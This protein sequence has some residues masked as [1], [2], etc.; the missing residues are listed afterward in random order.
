MNTYICK[1]GKTFQKSS[2]ADSTGYVLKNFDLQHECYGCPY[3]VTERDWITQEIKKQECRATPKITYV[4][5]CCIGT[6]DKNFKACHLYTLDLDFAKKVLDFIKSLD[7]AAKGD[8]SFTPN[9]FPNEW[10]AADFGLCYDFDDCCGLAIFPLCFQ[11]NK[12][13]TEARRTVMNRFFYSD[14]TRKDI[15]SDDEKQYILWQIENAKKQ[16]KSRITNITEE[17]RMSSKFDLSTML[18]PSTVNTEYAKAA[19]IHA[20]IINYA[21][22]AQENLYQMAL[23][24]KKMRDEKLYTAL[25]YDNFAEYCEKETGMKRGN[26]YKYIAVA[27]KLPQEFVSPVRQIGVQKLYL[28]TTITEDEREDIADTIDL[29]ST[30]VK[31]LKTKIDE[32][33]NKNAELEKSHNELEETQNIYENRIS[34]LEKAIDELENKPIEVA[35]Q[36]NDDEINRL[37]SELE[38]L[39]QEKEEKNNIEQ[40]RDEKLI[41][42]KAA[43]RNA[44]N[45][46]HTLQTEC[47][48]YA[49]FGGYLDAISLC[50]EIT[51]TLKKIKSETFDL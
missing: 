1:C 25:G 38:T 23:G 17:C 31:E 18:K 28:L 50:E 10:R 33:K 44:K 22:M 16:A 5:R 39:K 6:E 51:K 29:E 41:A 48:K 46:L 35:I 7:G 13:G 43:Y 21:K 20:E 37:K 40:E 19:E 34:E 45:S 4:T 27:E 9:I 8:S 3:I 36:D 49:N 47:I 12:K 30:T 32:L 11:N 26:V 2:N 15:S 14:G 42:F 24:F